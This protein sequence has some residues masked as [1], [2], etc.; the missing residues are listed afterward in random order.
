MR[1]N[2][3]KEYA[4][5]RWGI[6]GQSAKC[7]YGIHVNNPMECNYPHDPDDLCRCIQV[8]RFMFGEFEGPIC[9]H[10]IEEVAEHYKSKVWERYADNWDKLIET[11][12]TEWETGTAHETYALMEKIIEGKK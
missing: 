1:Y 5:D 3:F 12:K 9:Q 2:T 4:L 8:L 7:L 11:F 6:N 10:H